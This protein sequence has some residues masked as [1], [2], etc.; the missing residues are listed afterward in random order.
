MSTHIFRYV[1]R[2][3]DGSEVRGELAARDAAHV[4][5]LV[6]GAE[7]EFVSCERIASV[8]PPPNWERL[9]ER[10]VQA[11]GARVPLVSALQLLQEEGSPRLRHRVGRVIRRL[12]QGETLA[13]AVAH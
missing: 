5:E 6:T 10:T 4:A 11:V 13:G 12:E 2:D 8:T 1:A 7:L 9:G 3:R